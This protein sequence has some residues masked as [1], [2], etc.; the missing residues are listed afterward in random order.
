P[1]AY[2]T[3]RRIRLLR[4]PHVQKP[5]RERWARCA[6]CGKFRRSDSLGALTPAMRAE[7]AAHV[8]DYVQERALMVERKRLAENSGGSIINIVFDYT[9][10][11]HLPDW[12]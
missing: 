9:P 1:P 11:P 6:T 12:V 3:F 10:C 8:L 2:G 4:F 7:R 5:T